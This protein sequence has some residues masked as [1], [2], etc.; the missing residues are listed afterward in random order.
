MTRTEWVKHFFKLWATIGFFWV[1]ASIVCVSMSPKVSPLDLTFRFIQPSRHE[2]AVYEEV[3][4]WVA[5]LTFLRDGSLIYGLLG[6]L[7]F[8]R[9]GCL[10]FMIAAAVIVACQFALMELTWVA[11]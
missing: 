6:V 3:D 2:Q 9:R 11:P 8:F 1:V 10:V 7:I 5:R 4:R